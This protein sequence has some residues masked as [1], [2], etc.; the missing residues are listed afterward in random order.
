MMAR[1]STTLWLRAEGWTTTFSGLRKPRRVQPVWQI[2]RAGF[3]V[4]MPRSNWGFVSISSVFSSV[5]AATIAASAPATGSTSSSS[6]SSSSS[7]TIKN[8]VQVR[9][10][11]SQ[12]QDWSTCPTTPPATKKAIVSR[13]ETKLSAVE[14]SLEAH[15]KQQQTQAA[16]ESGV[17][18]SVDIS[19]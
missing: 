2:C 17:G 15:A 5:T 3:L 13:L 10:L 9:S 8:D 1:S 7:Q 6:S 18:G 4:R 12:I 16:A 14:S 11:K 19:A